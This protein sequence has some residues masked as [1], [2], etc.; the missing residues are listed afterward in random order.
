[1]SFGVVQAMIISLR[2]N[3]RK[4]QASHFDRQQMPMK[5]QRHTAEELLQKKATPQQL[6]RIKAKISA[7]STKARI[8]A[9][10]IT[11]SVML[12]GLLLIYFLF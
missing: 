10:V 3:S 5:D 1:M 7:E 6:Q 8:Q 2:N 12:L 4:K 9:I 11:L